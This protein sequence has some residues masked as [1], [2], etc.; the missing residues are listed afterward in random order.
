MKKLALILILIL[1]AIPAFAAPKVGTTYTETFD[2]TGYKL[3]PSTDYFQIIVINALT[4][5]L[6]QVDAGGYIDL[7]DFIDGMFVDE[8]NADTTIASTSE[9]VVFSLR[10]VGNVQA[11]NTSENHSI[12]LQMTP[13]VYT[14][15]TDPRETETAEAENATIDVLY[16]VANTR[17]IYLDDQNFP[18]YTTDTSGNITWTE[19]F[20]T[21][22]STQNTVHFVDG[23]AQDNSGKLVLNWNVNHPN[24]TITGTTRPVVWSARMAVTMALD[25][26]DFDNADYGYYKST[27]TVTYTA[28]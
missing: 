14:G 27:V 25:E 22:D 5:D 1:L 24:A 20:Y 11:A 9:Q 6:N 19:G 10:V 17:F 8:V 4:D 21:A 13:F 12:T 23:V 7:T 3:T 15:T 16:S 18:A 28:Q 2:V 26:A